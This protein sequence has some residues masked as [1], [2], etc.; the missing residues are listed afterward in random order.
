[1]SRALAI[2]VQLVVFF[3]LWMGLV[4][5]ADPWEVLVGVPAAALATW[6]SAVVAQTKLA[7]VGP[8]L[9]AFLAFRHLPK[10][11]LTGTWDILTVL[12][13]HLFT[14]E[15]AP[16]MVKRVKY[17][18]LSDSKEDAL[19]RA[20]AIAYTTMTPN[21]VVIDIDRETGELVYHQIEET[22]VPK[23]TVELGAQP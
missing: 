4:L 5:K 11:A 12:A 18:R 7:K 17:T 15:K 2:A 13:K 22:D 3:A 21:F 8:R 10:L 6:A 19:E 9:R 23:L 20:L 1:M 14:D 16:S